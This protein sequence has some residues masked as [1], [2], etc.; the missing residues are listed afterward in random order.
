[1]TRWAQDLVQDLRYAMRTLARQ[2]GFAGVAILSAALGIGACSTIFGLANFALFRS[3]PV[4]D[5]DR[6][7]TL[8]GLRPKGAGV[9]LSY[10]E[11]LDLRSRPSLAA[12]AAFFPLVPANIGS[13]PAVERHWGWIVTANYF[14]V[15]GLRPHLGR[16]FSVS[17][18]DQPGGS[19]VVVLSHQIWRSRFG[20]DASLVGREI[21]FNGRLVTVIGV[22]PPGFRGHEVALVADFWIPMSMVDQIAFPKGGFQRFEQRDSGWLNSVGRLQASTTLAQA[23][24]DLAV[25]AGQ[26]R[27]QFPGRYE[28]RGFH[29]E[30][31]GQINPYFRSVLLAFFTLLLVV[32]LLVLLVACANVANLLLAR[33]TSRRQEIATRL[34]IGAGR[35]RIVRQFLTESVLL[36]AL[37]GMG[38]WRW[39]VGVWA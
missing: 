23:R 1:M 21:R 36:A 15:L 33:S 24:A 13:A 16:T 29:I 4:G 8:S 12:V 37:G 7:V 31:A 18:D 25:L 6:L 34:A 39:P 20:G 3:L 28:D 22:A 17:Q 14:D 2:P 27:A 32:A 10:P 5:P 35:G 11:L 9:S 26:L 38:G 19:P 30:R